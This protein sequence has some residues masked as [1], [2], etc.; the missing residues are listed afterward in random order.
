M[1]RRIVTE[2]LTEIYS[3]MRLHKKRLKFCST[4]R[5]CI[6]FV[7]LF[8]LDED[9]IYPPAAIEALSSLM[10]NETFTVCLEVSKLV[11]C[12]VFSLLLQKQ[13]LVVLS[14]GVVFL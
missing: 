2:R 9:G 5:L 12:S 14:V 11:C 13:Y 8:Q 4:N 10:I 1:K 6:E 3:Q 7:L